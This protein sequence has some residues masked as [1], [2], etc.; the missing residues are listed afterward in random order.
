LLCYVTK[1]VS[2]IL[3]SLLN[4][5]GSM[6]VCQFN[7]VFVCV[8]CTV[9]NE[10]DTV[11]FSNLYSDDLGECSLP[12]IGH[13]TPKKEKWCALYRRFGAHHALSVL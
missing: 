8:R 12:Q 7:H 9:L 6:A 1:F 4:L 3:T 10:T 2:V 13:F 5:F 11:L